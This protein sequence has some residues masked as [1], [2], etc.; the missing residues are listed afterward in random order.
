M[1]WHQDLGYYPHTNDGV[2]AVLIYL[3]DAGEENGCV[4][5]MPHQHH[6]YLDHTAPGGSFAGRIVDPAIAEMAAQPLPAVAGSAIF[7]HGLTPHASLPNESDRS[8]RTLIFAYR[9]GD[10]YPL[11]Y[12]AVTVADEAAARLVRGQRAHHARFG[13]PSPIVPRI[14]GT[15]SLYELQ[16][17]DPSQ[18][19][20][21][22]IEP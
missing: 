19:D 22:Q 12:G 15:S 1:D 4:Q 5:V 2:L 18:V 7:I 10:A 21:P 14:D 8:R 3:D 13:G 20:D 17:A 16:A 11:Y 9:A 6:R